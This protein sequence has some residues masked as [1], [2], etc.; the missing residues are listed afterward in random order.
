MFDIKSTVKLNNGVAMPRFGL[1]VWQMERGQETVGAVL[2]ALEVGYRH[3]DTAKI[4]GNE[5][6]VGEAIRKSGVAREEIF[7]TT[8]LWNDDHDDPEKALEASLQ[9]LGMDYVDLYLIHWP[10]SDFDNEKT[11]GAMEKFP[12]VGKCKSV[13]V[14][15]FTI[16]HLSELLA[17]SKLVPA[18]NQVEFHPYLYQKE[19]LEYCRA[20]N[21]Q[22]EAYSPLTK[23]QR[24]EDPKL[25]QIASK[26]GKS[27][28]QILIRWALQHDLV[29]I[30]KS[31]NPER[32][33][34]NSEVFDF[35]ITPEDMLKLDGF[36][37][38]LRLVT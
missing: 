17:K 14:S 38:D 18:V 12:K 28:A 15:N 36:H 31:S 23:G 10:G 22:L 33:W 27:T 29:V 3:I 13:G 8:K 32:I 9:R 37:E 26:Y 5:A 20:Q 4:Y 19:L 16:Q 30:P 2:R 6:S 11:W 34:E 7:V 21:I 25:L 1:G 24:L 35:E